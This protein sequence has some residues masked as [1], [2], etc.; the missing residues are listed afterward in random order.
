MK[1]PCLCPRGPSC[2]CE[3][4][5]YLPIR[6]VDHTGGTLPQP[7]FLKKEVCDSIGMSLQDG[8]GGS[9]TGVGRSRRIV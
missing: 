4:F 5:R 8:F 6:V 9:A 3:L 1:P 2:L 7:S